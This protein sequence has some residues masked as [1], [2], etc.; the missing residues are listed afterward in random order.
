MGTTHLPRESLEVGPMSGIA[1]FEHSM[2]L[3]HSRVL[4]MF[5]S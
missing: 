1:F 2:R 4:P 5:D 3:T